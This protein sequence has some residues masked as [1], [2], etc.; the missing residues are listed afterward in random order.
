MRPADIRTRRQL[1]RHLES[2]VSLVDFCVPWSAPCREQ[3]GILLHL[4]RRFHGKARIGVMNVEENEELAE[5]FG[6]E[7]VPTLVLF[8]DRQ[9]VRR[10]VGLHSAAVL[11]LALAGILGE[12]G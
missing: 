4:V 5:A 12:K 2:G 3:Q 7:S 1:Q 6:I 8:Q 9:E 11:T 10:F